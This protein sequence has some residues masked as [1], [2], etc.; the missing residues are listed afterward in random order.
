MMKGTVYVLELEIKKENWKPV[1]KGN[2]M[3]QDIHF[4]EEDTKVLQADLEKFNCPERCA[5]IINNISS[6][7]ED[8]EEFV[9]NCSIVEAENNYIRIL[10]TKDNASSIDENVNIEYEMQVF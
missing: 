9:G 3:Q 1:G 7:N 10:T 4:A 5:M 2:T 8:Y 6:P